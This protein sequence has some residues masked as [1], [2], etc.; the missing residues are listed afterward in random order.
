MAVR[1]LGTLGGVGRV[2]GGAVVGTGRSEQ[3]LPLL[4]NIRKTP[5]YDFMINDKTFA[6]PRSGQQRCAVGGTKRFSHRGP[7]CLVD[8]RTPGR[9]G[10]GAKTTI[11]K[12]ERVRKSA[13]GLR[14]QHGDTK[15]GRQPP[16]RDKNRE[17]VFRKTPQRDKD[18]KK[19]FFETFTPACNCSAREETSIRRMSAVH[20][21]TDG[22]EKSTER[23]WL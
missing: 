13:M 23:V 4:Q 9:C 22:E 2:D 17:R 8:T 16:L 1:F 18:R 12:T 11:D 14:C 7:R 19:G 15:R 10:E 5:E 6:A 21:R 20:Q 3:R